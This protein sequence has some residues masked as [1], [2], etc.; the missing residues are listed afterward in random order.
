[1]SDLL[2]LALSGLIL[3]VPVIAIGGMVMFY[4]NPPLGSMF[5]SIQMM[6]AV[7]TGLSI[8][9]FDLK[10]GTNGWT[11]TL[12]PGQTYLDLSSGGPNWV[13]AVVFAG[14]VA[15]FAVSMR[16]WQRMPVVVKEEKKKPGLLLRYA[17]LVRWRAR[18]ETDA[19]DRKAS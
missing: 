7:G 11:G 8:G 1:M 4:R 18:R 19:I 13:G 6:M 9:S 5:A 14:A 10:I 17:R 2:T 16:A 12:M 3:L 15:V